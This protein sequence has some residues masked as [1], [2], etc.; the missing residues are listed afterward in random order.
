MRGELHWLL[1]AVHVSAVAVSIALLVV[2]SAIGI[3]STPERVPR[4]LR[5]LPHIVDT[6]LLASAVGLV[7]ILG[8]YPFVSP[9][10]TAKIL[11]LVV[12]IGVGAVAVRRGPTPGSRAIALVAALAVAAYIISTALHHEPAPWRW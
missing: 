5:V 6:V 3:H 8:Q 10:V 11:A 7:L 12:Y 4:A 2:R 1:R 9:W